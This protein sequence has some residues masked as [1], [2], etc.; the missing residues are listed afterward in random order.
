MILQQLLYEKIYIQYINVRLRIREKKFAYLD[1][2]LCTLICY[3]MRFHLYKNISTL[4]KI[5]VFHLK[6]LYC[7]NL[8]NSS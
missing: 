2:I 4:Y 7:K 5:L 6:N 3:T 1:V 8:I